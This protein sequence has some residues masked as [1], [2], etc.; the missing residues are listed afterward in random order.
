[1][2]GLNGAGKQHAEKVTEIYI[3]KRRKVILKP[4]KLLI[5]PIH[6]TKT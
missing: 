1:M 5:R 4:F 3:Y 2:I 6:A